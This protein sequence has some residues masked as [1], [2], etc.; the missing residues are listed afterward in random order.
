MEIRWEKSFDSAHRIYQHTAKCRFL[1]GHTYKVK[2]RA[3][4]ELDKWGMVVDF[5]DLKKLIIELLDHKI[6]LYKNDPILKQLKEAKQ[7]VIAIDRNPTAENIAKLIASRLMQNFTVNS[8]EV[9][10][11]ETATQ[12]GFC[13]M[14]KNSFEKVEFEEITED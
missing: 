8:V 7:R 2:V 11:F 6:I 4:G 14:D 1:H 3:E 13:R 10:I 12:S 5:G 9:E